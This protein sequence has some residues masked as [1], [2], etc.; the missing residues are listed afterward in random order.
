[1]KQITKIT[2]EYL[3]D[4][5]VASGD[6]LTTQGGNLDQLLYLI[7]DAVALMGNTIPGG[8]DIPLDNE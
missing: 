4:T 8:D 3:D 5:W 1:M 6:E 2:L 7:K